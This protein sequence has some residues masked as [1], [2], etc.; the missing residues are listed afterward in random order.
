M[1]KI[2]AAFGPIL[3]WNEPLARH[4][5]FRIGGPADAFARPHSAGE[6]AA[7]LRAA[8]GASVPVFIIGAGANILVSDKGIRGLVVSLERFR[9]FSVIGTA[10]RAGAGLAASALAAGTARAGLKGL[11]RFYAMP[12]SVGGAV[13]MNARCYESSFSDTLAS[14]TVLDENFAVATV[15]VQT[16]DFDYKKSPFQADA[17]VILAA[18]FALSPADPRPLRTVMREIERDRKT[19]GHFLA[20][21]AGSVFKNNRTFGRPS[22][23]LLDSLGLRGRRVGGAQ[24]SPRH[25]NIIINRHRATAEDVKKLIDLMKEE[26]KG[27]YGVELDW[28]ILYVGE[29]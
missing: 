11:E 10:V 14:V 21:S 16:S 2:F 28:E 26:V 19:K 23:R 5:S 7:L 17:R 12:G 3:K 20:P 22:G 25:A 8:R 6:L 29:E 18:E 13:W 15:R 27:R 4:T 1:K 9:E 24:V